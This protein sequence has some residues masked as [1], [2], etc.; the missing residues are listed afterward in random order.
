MRILAVGA[1]PDDLEQLCG[2][3]LAR[4]VAA[5]HAVTMCHASSGDRGSFVHTSEQIAAIRLDE[6]R[7]AASVIGA[8]Q[9]T[10]GLSDGAIYASDPAQRAL[11]IDLIRATRPDLIITHSPNDYMV[12]HNEVSKLMLDVSHLAT[13]P[14]IETS[15]R[16]HDLVAPV[17][18]MDTLAGVGFSPTEYV[19]ISDVLETKLEALGAHQS[20]LRWLAEHDG[21]DVIEQTRVVGAFRGFQSGVRYAE[22]FTTALTWLRARTERLLP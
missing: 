9:T 20:Q 21:I 2:G 8:D 17:F 4:Y 10:L 19:D 13:V 11:A 3:T 1:H 15:H 22:G 7:R 16:A 6:A 5:G 12:D 18:Y 14:L